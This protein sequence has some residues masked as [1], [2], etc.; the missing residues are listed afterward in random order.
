MHGFS[1]ENFM[2]IVGFGYS[3]RLERTKMLADPIL[4]AEF[5]EEIK[6]INEYVPENFMVLFEV[7]SIERTGFTNEIKYFQELSTD[8]LNQ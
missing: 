7:K 3:G 4:R 5:I 8:L 2:F 1:D 6:E